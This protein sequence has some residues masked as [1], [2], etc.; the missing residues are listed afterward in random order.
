MPESQINDE[1]KEFMPDMGLDT[2]DFFSSAIDV[3]GQFLNFVGHTLKEIISE[4][5]RL[6]PKIWGRKF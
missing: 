6:F 4:T 5:A 2:G 3:V 1:L